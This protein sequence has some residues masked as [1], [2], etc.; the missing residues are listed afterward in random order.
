MKPLPAGHRKIYIEYIGYLEK[1]KNKRKKNLDKIHFLLYFDF[2]IFIIK[3]RMNKSAE[4]SVMN[5]RGKQIC[6][7]LD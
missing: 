2:K 7:P 3:R 4:N 1:T 6:N 5:A